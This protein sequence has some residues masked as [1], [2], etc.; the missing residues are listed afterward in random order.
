MVGG[1][2]PPSG[3][4]LDSEL[5]RYGT[6]NDVHYERYEKM[7]G[8]LDGKKRSGCF[9]VFCFELVCMAPRRIFL[10]EIERGMESLSVCALC[11]SFAMMNGIEDDSTQFS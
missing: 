9:L 8:I 5:V 7:M 3:N 10:G 2:I 6:R 1:G 11:L 4:T